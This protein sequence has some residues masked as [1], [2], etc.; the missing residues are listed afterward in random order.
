MAPKDEKLDQLRAALDAVDDEILDALNRRARVVKEVAEHKAAQGTPFYVPDRERRVIERLEARNA[1]PFPTEA[2]QPVVR[3]I[4][5]AC[6]SLQKGVRVAYLGPEGT[7]THVA[8]KQHFGTSAQAVPAGTIAAV[9]EEV[10]RGLVDYGVVPVENSS[11]GVVNHTLDTFIESDVKICA[12]V[13]VE[14]AQCLLVRRGTQ[15]GAI[16]RVYSHPQALGQCRR[17]LAANLA[18]AALVESPSTADAARAVHGDAGGAAIASEFAAPLYDLQ[19]LRRGLQDV[20]DNHT[21]FL[22]LGKTEP[23]PATGD[24][25]TSVLMALRD[26]AGILF[27]V[28]RPLSDAGVNL[29][30][31][32]S[33]PSRRR[34]WEYVFF[35]DLDGHCRDERVARVLEEVREACELFQILGSY[36]KAKRV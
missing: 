23:P 4:M 12:E 24:D 20:P 29:S 6:L 1:G 30:K 17:W 2:I 3:E 22:V 18:R 28:L 11:E 25:K 13:L 15:E 34:A 19:V 27:R 33:R 31:I 10:D 36:P 16:E 5:S 14:V 9:F 21:R 26:E 32:E 35:L 7:F 8:A